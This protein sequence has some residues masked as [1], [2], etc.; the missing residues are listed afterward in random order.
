MIAW[1][2]QAGE[3]QLPRVLLCLPVPSM[4]AEFPRQPSEGQ[5]LLNRGADPVSHFWCLLIRKT[6]RMKSNP[7]M[8]NWGKLTSVSR[9][10]ELSA[11]RAY[12][13]HGLLPEFAALPLGLSVEM[14]M[15]TPQ[16]VPSPE[17]TQ[18]KQRWHSSSS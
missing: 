18:D 11:A 17:V 6:S 4:A 10:S 2:L 14:G 8:Q 13:R 7:F 1:Q 12:Q 3:Q 5:P 16:V 9:G 15:S